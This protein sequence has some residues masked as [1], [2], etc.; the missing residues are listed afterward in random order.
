[1]M[2]QWDEVKQEIL[3]D[4]KIFHFGTLSMTD[5]RIE[6]VTKKAIQ[7]AKDKGAVVSFDPNLRP[8]LWKNLED[9][10]RQMWYGIRQCDIL[11]ISDDEIEFLTG[12]ADIDK[13]VEK[14]ME[15]SHPTL[16][17]ATM[18]KHGSKAYYNG[19][20]IF[21]EPFLRED[22]IET[23]GAG[24]TFMACVLNAVLEKGIDSLNDNDLLDMLEFANAASSIITTRKGALMTR[25]L[26]PHLKWGNWQSRSVT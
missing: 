24:D 5:E 2:L 21:C 9:A 10:K 22:T 13:G 8:P 19:K 7:K 15:Q 12:T 18:G 1:M 17:C 23:T 6:N 16:I 3:A 25:L 14:I 4:T 11:K 26:I 20:S